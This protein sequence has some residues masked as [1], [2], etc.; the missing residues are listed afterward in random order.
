M[1]NPPHGGWANTT[2]LASSWKALPHGWHFQLVVYPNGIRAGDRGFVSAAIRVRPPAQM[3]GKEWTFPELQQLRWFTNDDVKLAKTVT[4]SRVLSNCRDAVHSLKLVSHATIVQKKWVIGGKFR[5]VGEVAFLPKSFSCP[6]LPPDLFSK[7][8]EFVTFLLADG[9]KLHLDK[10]LVVER[11][12]HFAN[13]LSSETWVEGRTNVIDLRSNEQA[14]GT[15][16][17]A[18]PRPELCNR[19]VAPCTVSKPRR[20]RSFS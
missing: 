1:D 2:N 6:D 10:R 16:M 19:L 20:D 7:E 13:M 5:I 11:S 15:S 9:S 8:P 17:Q 4:I 14:D 12:T 3:R 18:V